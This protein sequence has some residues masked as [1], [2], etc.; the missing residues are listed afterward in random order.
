MTIF[1]RVAPFCLTHREALEWLHETVSRCAAP[2][3]VAE[4]GSYKGGSAIVLADA[5]ITA[6]GG[7]LH[8]IDNWKELN[9]KEGA[10]PVL[11]SHEEFSRN[12]ND[13]FPCKPN[14]ELLHVSV[15]FAMYVDD[16]GSPLASDMWPGIFE[17]LDFFY[18]DGD[19]T[20]E[21]VK[22]D[23][24]AFLP[25]MRP[26]GIMCGH[27]Y[28][29]ENDGVGRAVRECFD[30]ETITEPPGDLWAVYV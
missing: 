18:I 11:A 29:G 14:G 26:G 24:Q 28:R 30:A 20:Y 12:F 6:G 4:I 19:H 21:A 1:D 17:L 5:I 2:V 15:P 9:G 13:A 10:R 16:R 3:H 8:C 27:D 23:I 25:K 22:R 7:D